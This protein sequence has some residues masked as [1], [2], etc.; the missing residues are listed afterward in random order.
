MPIILKNNTVSNCI[1]F[2][3]I[4]GAD[5]VIAEDN[6]ATNTQSMFDL[7]DVRLAELR[8]NSHDAGKPNQ[9][10]QGAPDPDREE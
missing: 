7:K 3:K 10:D 8:R 2:A 1:N 5:H 4:E 6:T 9:P